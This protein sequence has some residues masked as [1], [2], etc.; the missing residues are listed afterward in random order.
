M[1][2]GELTVGANDGLTS[3]EGVPVVSKHP[4]DD[5]MST[6]HEELL[7]IIVGD[8]LRGVPPRVAAEAL[9]TLDETMTPAQRSALQAVKDVAAAL[10]SA[11]KA[12]TARAAATFIA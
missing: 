3:V 1:A 12:A 11:L 5:L 10:R 8:E 4:T 9:A 2:F 6:S 7:L